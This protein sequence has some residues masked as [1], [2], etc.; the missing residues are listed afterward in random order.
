M[1]LSVA[2][3][4]IDGSLTTPDPNWDPTLIVAGDVMLVLSLDVNFDPGHTDY[5]VYDWTG[6]T[7]LGG[8]GHSFNLTSLGAGTKVYSANNAM[9]AYNLAYHVITSAEATVLNGGGF[10]TGGTVVTNAD[11]GG[12]TSYHTAVVRGVGAPTSVIFQTDRYDGTPVAVPVFPSVTASVDPL[13]ANAFNLAGAL[14]YGTFAAPNTNTMSSMSAP[15]H[16][17]NDVNSAS[18]GIWRR[19]RTG[20]NWQEALSWPSFS[21]SVDSVDDSVSDVLL[22][23]AQISFDAPAP[24]PVEGDSAYFLRTRRV[25]VRALPHSVHTGMVSE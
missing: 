11:P 23:L 9:W 14:A 24:D 13:P 5:G 19:T 18:A 16:G 3:Y 2:D 25:N 10:L 6:Y 4:G 21:T 7:F 17:L 1:A 20:A 15:L 22:V 8:S 12:V